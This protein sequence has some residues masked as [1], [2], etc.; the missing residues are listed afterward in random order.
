MSDI[1]ADDEVTRTVITVKRRTLD[2][3]K[4]QAAQRKISM[5]ALMREALDEKANE[6][7]P[8]PKSAGAFDSGRTDL[9]ELASEGL[10]GIPTWR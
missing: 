9:S 3:L 4:R 8:W 10:T 1:T 2:R 5:A 7:Q 6:A